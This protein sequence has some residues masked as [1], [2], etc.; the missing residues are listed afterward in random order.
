MA[1]QAAYEFLIK[2][3]PVDSLPTM[4]DGPDPAELE[5][6]PWKYF[7]WWHKQFE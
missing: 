3:A 4:E 6:N 1:F 2:G 5:E 7:A